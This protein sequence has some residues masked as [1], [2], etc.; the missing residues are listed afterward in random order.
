[1]SIIP[2]LS[3]FNW[4]IKR[5]KALRSLSSMNSAIQKYISFGWSSAVQCNLTHLKNQLTSLKFLLNYS[6]YNSLSVSQLEE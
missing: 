4:L 2:V 3:V 6:F 1:M 5:F